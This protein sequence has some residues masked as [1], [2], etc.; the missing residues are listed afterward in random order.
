MNESMMLMIERKYY[1]RPEFE[2]EDMIKFFDFWRLFYV[3]F[4]RAQDLLVLTCNEETNT[5]S[6]YFEKLY[7]TLID[8]DEGFDVSSIEISPLKDSGTRNIYSFTKHI[9]LYETCPMQY[10]FFSEL[11]FQPDI[12]N[13]TFMGILIHATLEDIHKAAE[14]HE[15]GKITEENIA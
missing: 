13:H 10:K 8:A 3:A 14:K 7:D 5:P 12:S 11:G 1:K 6:R 9:L 2:P 4:S 15:E